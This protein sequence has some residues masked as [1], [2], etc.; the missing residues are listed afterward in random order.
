MSH[1]PQTPQ[2]QKGEQYVVIQK[3]GGEGPCKIIPEGEPYPAIYTQVYGPASYDDCK[4]WVERN[5]SES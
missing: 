5:C 4:A 2:Q 3:L 1:N